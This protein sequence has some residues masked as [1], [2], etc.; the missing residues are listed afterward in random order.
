[1]AVLFGTWRSL[2]FKKQLYAAALCWTI[3]MLFA[4]SFESHHRRIA[5][6]E[7]ITYH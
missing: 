3:W 6:D 2:A 1:M 7:N 5:V 4:R